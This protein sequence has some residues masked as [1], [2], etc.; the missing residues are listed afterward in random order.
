SGHPGNGYV[1]L[2]LHTFVGDDDGQVREVVREP[3]IG[4]LASAL[5]LTEKAAWSFPA[6][7]ERASA[8]GQ[9]LSQIFAAAR[10]P[11]AEK[12][13]I[14]SHALERYFETSGLFGT[15]ETC[16]AMVERLKKI[17]IDELACLIDFGVASSAALQHLEHL[18]RVR[19]LAGNAP[20]PAAGSLAVP[21]L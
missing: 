5:D 13:A 20:A 8:T 11:P 21:A 12:S 18:N 10:L 9:T 3:M 6:F 15:A 16:L 17:E 7:K 14:L 2:M 1:T 4:Y 19:E